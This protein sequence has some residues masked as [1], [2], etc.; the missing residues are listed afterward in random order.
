MTKNLNSTFTTMILLWSFVRAL[1]VVWAVCT[2]INAFDGIGMASSGFPGGR[3]QAL[4]STAFLAVL[5][6]AYRFATVQ[7]NKIIEKN[8]NKQNS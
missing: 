7:K 2:T 8:N 4:L 3:E 6:A 1:I 5:A